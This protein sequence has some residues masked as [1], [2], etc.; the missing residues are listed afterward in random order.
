MT[1]SER[2]LAYYSAK[3][4]AD[5]EEALRFSSEEAERLAEQVKKREAEEK[6]E[7]EKLTLLK[8]KQAE[9]KATE[10]FNRAEENAALAK[11]LLLSA[12][13]A[14]QKAKEDAVN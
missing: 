9:Q 5:L 3:K 4:N 8:A 1:R 14:K 11:A 13:E 10:A 7:Q 2:E 6:V 12:E